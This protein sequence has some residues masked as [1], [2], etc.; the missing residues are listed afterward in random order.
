M[1]C[2]LKDLRYALVYL[3]CYVKFILGVITLHR[4]KSYLD[5]NGLAPVV[6]F[7]SIAHLGTQCNDC[8]AVD[9]QYG[10][11]KIV[12]YLSCLVPCGIIVLSLTLCY[13]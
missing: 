4:R 9:R 7:H 11:D 12:L 1:L 8:V 5:R 3:K 13:L 2:L 10:I 6:D